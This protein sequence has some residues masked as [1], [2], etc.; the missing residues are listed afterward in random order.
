MYVSS[1]ARKCTPFSRQQVPRSLGSQQPQ[2]AEFL[3]VFVP[4]SFHVVTSCTLHAL[5]AGLRG[6][7][8]AR[9]VV[10]LFS[11]PREPKELPPLTLELRRMVSLVN[12]A[13]MGSLVR[14]STS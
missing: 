1:A 14:E 11:C 6:N 8:T 7:K 10:A 4:R 5:E 13:Q 12:Q 9:L 3:T 2:R